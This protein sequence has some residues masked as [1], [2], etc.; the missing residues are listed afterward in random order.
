M[1]KIYIAQRFEFD[2]NGSLK[3]DLRSLLL[4]SEKYLLDDSGKTIN[5]LRD[6]YKYVGPFFNE[7]AAEHD[8]SASFGE[9][10]VAAEKK[11]IDNCDVFVAIFDNE[12][13]PGTVTELIYALMKHKKCYMFYYVDKNRSE[14][15]FPIEFAK[16]LGVIDISFNNK[17]EFKQDILKKQQTLWLTVQ[18]KA[19]ARNRLNLIFIE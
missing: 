9:I 19:N 12:V 2:S 13:S 18:T 4:G 16:K 6:E 8:L 1:K 10:V 3:N 5:F 11:A 17:E 14:N 15:W 7:K